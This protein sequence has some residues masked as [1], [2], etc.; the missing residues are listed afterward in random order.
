MTRTLW[1]AAALAVG[2]ASWACEAPDDSGA[3]TVGG[4][5][6][7]DET[8]PTGDET[9]PTGDETVPTANETVPAAGEQSPQTLFANGVVWTGDPRN[10][11]AEAVLVGNGTIEYVG[12]T[13]V[14]A[15]RAGPD[16]ETVDLAGRMLL[17]GFV[18]SHT[19][20]AVAGLIAAALQV[21]GT[22]T[23]AQVQEALAEY[24]AANPEADVLFGFGFPGSLASA[25]DAAGVTGPRKE[26]LDAVVSDRPVMI[27]A[28]D[29]HSAWLNSRALEVAGIDR[30]TPDPVPGVHFYQRDA[31]GEPTGWAVEGAAFWPLLPVFGI[32]S[33]AQF[34]AALSSTLPVL[35]S[36]GVTTVF[37]AGIPGGE[38][39]LRNALSAVTALERDG[40]LP[41]RYRAS[42]Y[43][44]SPNA[45]GAEVVAQIE[46]VR[47]DF[48]SDL[49][50]VHTV[51]IAIDGTFEGQT[52]AVLEPY[53]SGGSGAVALS[54]EPLADL[55][56][57]LREA[58]L[59]AH[60]HAI[61]DR[62]LRAVLD[63]V[64][65]ARE[66]VPDSDSRVAVAHVM[67]ASDED[68]A[69]MRDL[70]VTIQTTPHWA[71]DMFGSL[72]LYS[73]LLD[74]AR[75]A[76]IM[77]LRD[78]WDAAPLVAFGADFPATGLPF[79]LASPLHGI[80]IGMTRLA[81]GASDGPAY[82][83]DGQGLALEEMLLGYTTNGAR[84]L[85]LEGVTGAI[86]PGLAADLVVVDRD[87]FGIAP[88]EIDRAQI[89]MTMMGGRIVFRRDDATDSGDDVR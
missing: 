21:I 33:E 83:P 78:M 74:P 1:L 66:A 20:P 89:D 84:Q 53:A 87:L 80:K 50:D 39:T 67:L 57:A 12:T 79:P 29:A 18:E 15:E 56:A 82:P 75:G 43:V 16:A 10:P 52:A 55:F 17:P 28:V 69:R 45:Q 5:P 36:M 70:D 76:R 58:G 48:A 7:G 47:R 81:P 37:D 9:V 46:A 71:H 65:A 30:N 3:S 27:L 64:A 22:E 63:A 61:G 42:W 60:A 59:D 72:E 77:R 38:A 4:V 13:A 24:G 2:C 26:D 25:V 49:L 86:R 6:T 11:R 8:V 14:A 41:V 19:H 35:S 44:D 31:S 23:V 34:R 51:K 54:G 85:G 88:H 32:G 73:T 40:R 68:L 62:T